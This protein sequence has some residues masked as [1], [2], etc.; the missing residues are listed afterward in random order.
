MP[1]DVRTALDD[2]KRVY[3]NDGDVRA[4]IKMRSALRDTELDAVCAIIRQRS[5]GDLALVDGDPR[6]ALG[7]IDGAIH[8]DSVQ[9]RSAPILERTSTWPFCALLRVAMDHETRNSVNAFAAAVQRVED[10]VGRWSSRAHS[11]ST[12]TPPA[13]SGTVAQESNE[14]TG[15]WWSGKGDGGWPTRRVEPVFAE[16]A[17]GWRALLQVEAGG[18]E[19]RARLEE[20]IVSWL[21]SKGVPTELTEGH[22]LLSESMS[23]S[24][25]H[26]R[27]R[28]VMV[29]SRYLV[30]DRNDAGL[31]TVSASVFDQGV[32]SSY[33][34]V[35]VYSPYEQVRGSTGLTRP[36]YAQPPRYLAGVLEVLD[37]QDGQ[38]RLTASP[39]EVHRS[40]VED[41]LAMVTDADRRVPVFVAGA[42]PD[43]RHDDWARTVKRLTRDVIGL[44]GIF[45]LTPGAQSE[46]T[47]GITAPFSVPPG[48]LRTYL[49]DTDPAMPESAPRHKVLSSTRIL[50]EPQGRMAKMLGY[51]AREMAL[52]ITLPHHLERS[53]LVLSRMVTS[54]RMLT[55]TPTLVPASR[56]PAPTPTTPR[57]A[58]EP[59]AAT[60]ATFQDAEV[61][62]TIVAELVEEAELPTTVVTPTPTDAE[63]DVKAVRTL[64]G[65]LA[66]IVRSLFGHERLDD[67]TLEE[68]ERHAVAGILAE[69]QEEV[70][71]SRL[72]QERQ[73][74]RLFQSDL[75]DE[76]LEHAETAER[77]FAAES[78]LRALHS[79]LSNE[80]RVEVIVAAQESAGEYRP[81]DF[82]ELLARLATMEGPAQVD[83]DLLP[84]LVFTGS[85][86]AVDDL[87]DTDTMDIAVGKTWDALLALEDYA[88]MKAQGSFTG[89]V[90]MYCQQTPPQC[91]GW[92]ANRHA[93]SESED[94]HKRP[95][96]RRLRELPVPAHIHPSGI[97]FMEAHFKLTQNRSVSPRMHY[98]DDT[99]GSGFIY[100]GYIG[101]HLATSEG[102]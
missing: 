59:A 4:D 10:A 96:L 87:A 5:V 98:H 67:G 49:P 62:T 84:H 29:A 76:L 61:D 63:P 48:S 22:R 7:R 64:L 39:I 100:I 77:L 28:E 33:L 45:I 34:W 81:G 95:N 32:T 78:Q 86:E 70:L 91:H 66:A 3:L 26:H 88:R 93:P 23:L 16:N 101:R 6:A 12:Q 55:P 58:T 20:Q 38:T 89:N 43:G 17:L 40:G 82:A 71:L 99:A 14:R 9:W 24:V 46:F 19:V 37:A 80:G 85:R 102:A 11:A 31:W 65:K 2:M 52:S 94:I 13:Q 74:A 79:Q 30:E 25:V 18:A 8:L 68:L 72:D 92:S 56:G 57:P 97:A 54:A 90:H 83:T 60:E 47:E 44:G 1:N 36:R 50:N 15:I 53:D 75:E 41:L 21:E 69:E 27:A 35:D 73:R 51:R 42:A